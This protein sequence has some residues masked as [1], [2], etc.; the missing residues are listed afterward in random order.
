MSRTSHQ[1]NRFTA[2][3]KRAI[4]RLG[5]QDL[6]SDVEALEQRARYLGA[7]VTAHALNRAKNALSWE[8]ASDVEQAGRAA[9][10]QRSG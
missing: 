10:G 5:M 6:A 2:E 9:R 8:I 7:H 4:N 1:K 3:D